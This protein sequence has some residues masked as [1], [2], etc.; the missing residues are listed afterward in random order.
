[1]PIFRDHLPPC[2][3]TC[4]G[5]FFALRV[6]DDGLPA[7][8][9]AQVQIA[10]RRTSAFADRFRP[11]EGADGVHKLSRINR[12]CG[13]PT[14]V[15]TPRTVAAVAIFVNNELRVRTAAAVAIFANNDSA[16]P[17]TPAAQEEG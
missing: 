5:T 2:V 6:H 13:V 7:P 15:T 11:S 16:A 8:R 12:G 10:R 17:R 3:T 1:M 9:K 4:S 14:R